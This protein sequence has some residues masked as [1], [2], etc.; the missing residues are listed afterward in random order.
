L[1]GGLRLGFVRASPSLAL[2]FARVKATHDLGSSVVSQ[3]LAHRILSDVEPR[4]IARRRQIQ[5]HRRYDTLA[6]GLAHA[7]P[8][9]S[10]R[11]PAGGLSIWVR[12]PTADAEAF[13]RLALQHGVAVATSQP[14]SADGRHPDRLRLS[15]ALPE[16]ELE[17]A[18]S[19][20][21]AAWSA[22][23]TRRP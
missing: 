9:W 3:V 13:A 20:L 4:E 19:R 17:T 11:A 2:R 12:L 7:L 16:A 10:W 1:W 6:A 22:L 23:L 21:A 5:L 15:F 8:S 18:V 14:L